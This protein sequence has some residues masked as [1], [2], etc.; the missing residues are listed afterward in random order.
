MWY[1]QAQLIIAEASQYGQ[2]QDRLL[3]GHGGGGLGA[4]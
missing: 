2:Q 3:R 1:V 4:P